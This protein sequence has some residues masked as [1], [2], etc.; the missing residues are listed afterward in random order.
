MNI[1][2]RHMF[3]LFKD[4]NWNMFQ[5]S[6]CSLRWTKQY[7]NQAHPA[8]SSHEVLPQLQPVF[9]KTIKSRDETTKYKKAATVTKEINNVASTL[10]GSRYDVFME[11]LVTFKNSMLQSDEDHDVDPELPVASTSRSVGPEGSSHSETATENNHVSQTPASSSA[12]AAIGTAGPSNGNEAESSTFSQNS[13]IDVAAIKLPPK[14]K[15]PGRQKGKVNTAVGLKRKANTTENA[16]PVKK[17]FVDLDSKSQ[18]LNLVRWLTNK[19]AEQI[20]KKKTA[21]HEI[22][23]DELV[24]NRLR[25]D[26]LGLTG[27]KKYLEHKAYRYLLDEVG[28]INDKSWPC[29]KCYRNLS[30]NQ[31]MCV[32]CLD[33]Y[34][35]QCIHSDN[36]DTDFYCIDCSKE[37]CVLFE[38]KE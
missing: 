13:R 10:T 25:N 32:Q 14:I 31:T 30:G 27:M 34:H 5:P 36:E 24:F 19:T 7:Y 6:V 4:Q 2:C 37:D 1:P 22:I 12:N 17:K 9:A 33:W 15:N 28:K 26:G 16:I 20:F 29:A 21:R 8:L 18:S 11:K 23:E 35:D 3:Q 38:L